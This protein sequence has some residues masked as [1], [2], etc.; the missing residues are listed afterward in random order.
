M[1]A[2]SGIEYI[3]LRPRAIIGR[4][5][6][7]IMP[8]LLRAHEEGRLR[9]IGE[10][11]NMMDLT[12]VSNVVQAVFLSLKAPRASC[13]EVYNVTNDEPIRLWEGINYT[14]KALGLKEVKQK[15]PY[16]LA[17]SIAQVA[18]LVGKLRRSRKEPA[19]VPYSIANLA[20]SMTL[21][22]SKIKEKLGY[23]PVQSTYEAIDEFVE[24]YKQKQAVNGLGV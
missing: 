21:D 19:I 7:V 13:G 5:D 2:G 6:R 23:R 24:W 12:A 17:L 8:R 16:R 18:S 1:I 10:G 9:V 11:T 20:R 22:I 3:A 4:G 15:I 14:L